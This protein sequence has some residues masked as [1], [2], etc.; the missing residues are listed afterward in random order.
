MGFVAS[1][2][3]VMLLKVLHF[4][5]LALSSCHWAVLVPN[6]VKGGKEWEKEVLKSEFSATSVKCCLSSEIVCGPLLLL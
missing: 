4:E 2:L 5:L 3:V 1:Y 6:S